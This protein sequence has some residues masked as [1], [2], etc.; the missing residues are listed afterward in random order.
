M[1]LAPD[2]ARAFDIDALE[3]PG[4]VGALPTTG[5]GPVE[6]D[7]VCRRAGRRLCTVAQWR[8]ACSDDGRNP[9]LLSAETVTS[10][11]DMKW[12]L[13]RELQRRCAM[14]E[15]PWSQELVPVDSRPE[16]RGPLP[17]EGLVGN[18]QEW[19]RTDEPG[20]WAL[21]GGHVGHRDPLI[22][23]CAAPMRV[24]GALVP[25]LDLSRVGFRCCA[26]R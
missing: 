11:G 9:Y 5:L 22:A 6:A 8:R 18:A 1:A 3:R 19:A 25:H 4:R 13:V 26:T 23:S 7:R 16:C 24:P 17:I 2:H 20:V 12:A 14:G 15:P 21:A 10:R